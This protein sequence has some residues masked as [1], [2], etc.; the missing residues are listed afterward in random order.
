MRSVT[1]P[2]L[3]GIEGSA[4]NWRLQ[5]KHRVIGIEKYQTFGKGFEKFYSTGINS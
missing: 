4:P 2:G 3:V 1:A 5:S